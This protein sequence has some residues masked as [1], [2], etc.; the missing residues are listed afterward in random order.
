M[1]L[2]HLY[3]VSGVG[4]PGWITGAAWSPVTPLGSACSRCQ[5]DVSTA[6]RA[7]RTT[8][9]SA[10]NEIPCA[11]SREPS[12]VNMLKYR[13]FPLK[14]FNDCPAGMAQ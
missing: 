6:G 10:G 7:I 3:S 4:S 1:H 9:S 5:W 11:K 14:I 8:L 12:P 2:S 13:D